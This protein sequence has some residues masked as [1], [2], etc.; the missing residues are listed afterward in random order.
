MNNKSKGKELKEKLLMQRGN[1]AASV[2]GDVL[3]ASDDYCQAYMRFLDQG[4]TERECVR[5][6]VTQAKRSGFVPFDPDHA[7]P[8]GSKIYVNNRDKAAAL[9]VVGKK[10]I[11]EGIRIVAAHIDSPRLDLKPCPLFEKNDLAFFKTHYYGGIKKYQWTALPLALHG[12][13][14]KKDGSVLDLRI[15]EEAGEPQFCVTDLL[16]HLAGEQMA[17][18]MAKGIRGEDLNILIG[19]R[20][21]RDEPES[22]ESDLVKLNIMNWL[23]EKHNL[24]EADFV[25]AELELVPAFKAAHIGFDQSM[26][27]AYGQDDRVCAYPALTAILEREAP[28]HTILAVWADKEEIGS[29]GSTGMQSAWIS[30]MVEQLAELEQTRAHRV[31]AN[32]RCLSADVSPAFDPTY[33]SVFEPGNS[34]FLNRGVVITK[35]TGSAGKSNTSDASAEF[36]GEIRALLD[37]SEILWQTG[38]LGKVDAG[39]GGTIAKFI[40]NLNVDVVDIGAPVLSMHAPFEVVS[41]LDVYMMHKAALAFFGS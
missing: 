17:K 6:A 31:W 26:I 5:Y 1:G 7:Y 30:Q 40:A 23:Y 9:A 35:Y 8:P 34:C 2:S 15:G 11:R 39:G 13:I 4:K 41:K 14:I 21:F 37:Q 28:E 29:N 32:S 25:S 18:T 22:Q 20:P 24:V 27:G 36:V 12:R 3:K 38:E 33:H 16:P 19:S 10:S